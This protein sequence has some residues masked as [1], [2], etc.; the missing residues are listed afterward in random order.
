LTADNQLTA[1]GISA[2]ARIEMTARLRQMA[3]RKMLKRLQKKACS[4][5]GKVTWTPGILPFTQVLP[6]VRVSRGGANLEA[7]RAG[8]SSSLFRPLPQ[9]FTGFL[10]QSRLL[11][12]LELYEGR[13][14]WL[15][16]CSGDSDAPRPLEVFE[17]LVP[18]GSEL[19]I[20]DAE[21]G[22]WDD[23]WLLRRQAVR[24]FLTEMELRGRHRMSGTIVRLTVPVP[25]DGQSHGFNSLDSREI[26][27]GYPVVSP[28]HT[29]G[30][31]YLLLGAG[32]P[33]GRKEVCWQTAILFEANS[34]DFDKVSA[35]HARDQFDSW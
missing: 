27:D 26:K 33:A 6:V 4:C 3:D 16:T 13:S 20:L 19:L 14:D 11:T 7:Q 29:S 32:C 28:W 30:Y 18:Q 23:H 1:A 9:V 15:S 34:A 5:D 22:H 2:T 25:D 24:Y 35:P 31:R 12:S 10:H 21:N 17:S 8:T